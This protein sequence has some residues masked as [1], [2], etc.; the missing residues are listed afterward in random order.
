[1]VAKRRL[2]ICSCRFSQINLLSI[3]FMTGFNSFTDVIWSY[4]FIWETNFNPVN[5]RYDL[6]KFGTNIFKIC[7]L[8]VLP[9]ENTDID[10]IFSTFSIMFLNF[11]N[12]DLV[13]DGI[14]PVDSYD[15]HIFLILFWKLIT[16]WCFWYFINDRSYCKIFIIQ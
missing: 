15:P 7:P 12:C 9:Y 13:C 3:F 2:K 4:R 11:I 10:L 16:V 14:F 8:V 5:H 1:M 6:I